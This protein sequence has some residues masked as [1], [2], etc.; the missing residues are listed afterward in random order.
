LP[1]DAWG[2]V[3]G[4]VSVDAE[5]EDV[6]GDAAVAAGVGEHGVLDDVAL[7][8]AVADGAAAHGGNAVVE[9]G[10]DAGGGLLGVVV[11]LDGEQGDPVGEREDGAAVDGAEEV[12]DFHARGGG[13]LSAD[14][15][16]CLLGEGGLALRA[17]TRG[18]RRRRSSRMTRMPME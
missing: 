2:D 6:V 10:Q 12:G 4:D 18:G 8:E 13:V 17:G 7:V 1:A 5:I 11:H 16:E 9:V 15:D 3:V 14:N